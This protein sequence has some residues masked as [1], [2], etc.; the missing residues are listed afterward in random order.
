MQTFLPFPSS[1]TSAVVL[2]RARLGKQRVE[3]LQILRALLVPGAGWSRHPA[4]LMWLRHE[5]S[6]VNYSL[7]MCLEWRN[8]G[9]KDTCFEKIVQLANE[10]R[11]PFNVEDQRVP[12]WV[13]PEFCRAHQS[14]LIRKLPEHYVPFFPGVP[15]DLPYIWPSKL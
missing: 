13:T 15:S 4:T 12:A 14:N 2:D 11:V 9:Y 10:H 3:C 5:S 6:L 7:N 1:L 8:R